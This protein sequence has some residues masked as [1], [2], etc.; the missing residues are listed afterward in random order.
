[1][2]KNT[3]MLSLL[4]FSVSKTPSTKRIGPHNYNI[5]CILI[6]S[7]LGDGSMERDGNGSRFVFYQKGDHVEYIL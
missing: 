7:L 6:G 1:M 5:L 2:T 3:S 4:P